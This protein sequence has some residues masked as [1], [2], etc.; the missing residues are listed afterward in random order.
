MPVSNGFEVIEQILEFTGE[1][2]LPRPF[3][4]MM[5]SS[6][7]VRVYREEAKRLGVNLFIE[8]PIFKD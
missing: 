5:T 1:H 4:C 6:S 8:K 2:G 7:K 3:F